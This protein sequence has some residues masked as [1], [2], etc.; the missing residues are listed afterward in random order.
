[1]IGLFCYSLKNI[2]IHRRW[3]VENSIGKCCI[4]NVSC[5]VD[6]R[7]YGA[8]GKTL[9]H[10]RIVTYAF[11]INYCCCELI[12][13]GIVVAF[14][15]SDFI[16]AIQKVFV[17]LLLRLCVT[18]NSM[19]HKNQVSFFLISTIIICVCKLNFILFSFLLL[20]VRLNVY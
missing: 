9:A 14:A 17:I 18:S 7:F 16:N 20:G 11:P 4:K 5:I 12:F 13:R 19:H 1:M 8:P 10:F 3:Y 2:S 6:W 15:F